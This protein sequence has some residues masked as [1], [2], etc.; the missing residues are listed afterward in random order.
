MA[1]NKLRSIRSRVEA[2]ERK[3]DAENDYVPG[4]PSVYY[5]D[6]ELAQM[7]KLLVDEVANI[8]KRIERLEGQEND[9]TMEVLK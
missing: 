8:V 9:T 5:A 2:L 3:Y 4:N 1:S 7:V 6:M